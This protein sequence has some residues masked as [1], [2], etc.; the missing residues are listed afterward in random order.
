MDSIAVDFPQTAPPSR[1]RASVGPPSLV[2]AF[3]YSVIGTALGVLAGTS[4]G[5]VTLR[6]PAPVPSADPVNQTSAM[7]ATST[8][9][10]S[11]LSETVKNFTK[12]VDS[13]LEPVVSAHVITPI[14]AVSNKHKALHASHSAAKQ[15]ASIKQVSSMPAAPD[16]PSQ[17]T[18]ALPAVTTTT[19]FTEGDVTVANFDGSANEARIETY[20]GSSFVVTSASGPGDASSLAE[21]GSN[22][23]Y[24]CDQSGNCTLSHSG[25]TIESAKLLRL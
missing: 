4:L 15:L 8:V 25:L 10:P 13:I 16:A 21:G 7:V 5:L 19:F 18:V 9:A 2:A 22:L 11:L 12:K 23:H 14:V 20:E 6:A 1:R 17:K 3:A 24:R